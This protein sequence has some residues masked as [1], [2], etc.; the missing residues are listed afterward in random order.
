MEQLTPSIKH[1]FHQKKADIFGLHTLSKFA[2]FVPLIKRHGEL[3][4]IFQIRSQ[5][6]RQPGEISFPGGKVDNTDTTIEEAA[7]RELQ[8]ELGI[9]RNQIELLGELDYMVT[10]F[11][12]VLYPFIGTISTDATFQLNKDEVENIFF[13]PVSQLM[14]MTPKE[15][16]IHLEVTPPEDFPYHLIPNG[17]NYNWRTVTL[18]EQFYEFDGHVIWGLT[19]RILTHALEEL[20]KA[21][22]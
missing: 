6:I 22:Y 12:F 15:H 5:Y 8:E 14:K 3:N 7:I 19:A 20:K 9:Q 16:P 17:Q 18:N 2:I 1:Y 10:P 21:S 13:A 11:R 4:F